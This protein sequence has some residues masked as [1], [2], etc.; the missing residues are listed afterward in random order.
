[1]TAR[2]LAGSSVSHR[3]RRVQR[4]R[5]AC[6]T[7]HGVGSRKRNK[8]RNRMLWTRGREC[9][10]IAGAAPIESRSCDGRRRVGICSS[11]RAPQPCRNRQRAL[12][13][14]RRSPTASV[15]GTWCLCAGIDATCMSPWRRLGTRASACTDRRSVGIFSDLPGY[16]APPSARD[17]SHAYRKQELSRGFAPAPPARA[18]SCCCSRRRW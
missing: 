12:F 5:D 4:A 14:N 15:C 13:L 6:V 17:S 7:Q 2:V 10:R 16:N 3:G 18:R 9:P 1:M 8:M 11:I